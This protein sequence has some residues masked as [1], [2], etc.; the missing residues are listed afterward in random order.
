M[1][2]LILSDKATKAEIG[3]VSEHFQGYIKVVVDIENRILCA[4]ADRHVDEEQELLKLGSKQS[5]LWGGGIDIET[6]EI[7]YNSMVNIRPNQDNPSRDIMSM[8]I[9]K[10]FDEIVTKI[11]K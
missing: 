8:E 4:G 9:R 1:N 2:V 7:D 5:N 3:K 6:G 10:T 11:L